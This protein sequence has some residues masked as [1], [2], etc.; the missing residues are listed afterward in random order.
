MLAEFRSFHRERGIVSYTEV[1]GSYIL[2]YVNV[3]SQLSS[4]SSFRF[5]SGG[6]ASS[7]AVGLVFLLSQLT[8]PPAALSAAAEAKTA[9]A[10]SL[11]IST[12][13]GSVTSVE[14]GTVVTLT[15]KVKAGGVA[16]T[17]GQVNF[18]NAGGEFCT[19]VDLLGTASVTSDGTAI[20]KFAPAPGSHSYKAKFLQDGQGKGSSSN[21][22]SLEVGP[23][24]RPHYSGTT[25]LGW[26]GA[27]GNYSLTA[28]V[29]G[30]GGTAAPTG[31]ISFVDTNFSD[32]VLA[33]AQLGTA[34]PGVGWSILQT[35][36]YGSSLPIAEVTADFNGDGLPDLAVLW[37][38]ASCCN[39][40]I[41][42]T[43]FFG[44]GNG[45]FTKGPTTQATGVQQSQTMIAGDFNADG[46]EDLAILSMSS[47]DD[48]NYVTALLGDGN[49][50]FAAPIT[51]VASQ[52]PDEGG[53]VITG[54]LVAA[55][56]NGDG[57]LDIAVVGD[58]VDTGGVAVL[59][60][61]GDGSFTATGANLAPD[62]GYG[63]IATGDFNG[64]GIPDLLATTYFQP[65]G[66]TVFLGQGNGK[67]TKGQQFAVDSFPSSI[68]V[69]DFNGDGKLDLAFG[70]EF[71]YST[72]VI[73]YLGKGDGT[74]LEA[75]GSPFS[76]AGQSLVAGDFNGDGKLDLAGVDNYNLQIDLFEGVGDGTFTEIVTTPNVSQSFIGP[77][78]IVAA[79]FN[80]DGVPDLA[81]LTKNQNTATALLNELTQTAT[82][83]V[84]GIAPI[85]AGTHNVKANYGGDS[86][87]G[88]SISAAVQLTAGLEPPVITPASGTYA[89]EQKVAIAEAIPGATI[90]YQAS[91]TVNTNG[92]LQY[93]GPF[94]LPYG[95]FEEISAYSTEAG[96]Q[97]SNY[98][99]ATYN[100]NLPSASNPVFSPAAG[101]YKETQTVTITDAVSGAAIYYTTN[102]TVAS[103]YSTAYN[104]PI[105]VS[106]SEV[107][108]AVAIAPGY[109]MSDVSSAQYLIGSSKTR[110]VYTVAGT[111]SVGYSGDGGPATF[112]SLEGPT[113]VARDAGGDLYIADGPTV[114]RVAAA[115]DTIT[116]VAGN[117]FLGYS[118][119]NGPATKARL[120][121]VRGLAFDK[122]GDLYIADQTN[123]VVRK[124]AAGSGTITTVAGNGKEGDTGDNGPATKA[125]LN[126]PT[127]LAVDKLGNLYIGSSAVIR[128]VA[129]ATGT[130]T[131]FAGN[132]YTGYTGDGG[133][134]TNAE[135]GLPSAMAFDASGDLYFADSQENVVRRIAA[136]TSIITTVAGTGPQR[137]GPPGNGDGGPATSAMLY[138]PTGLAI[139]SA[140]DLFIS[141]TD[142]EA[143]REVTATNK[144]INTI[145]G[146]EYSCGFLGGDGGPALAANLCYPGGLTID[147][148]GN[149]YVTDQYYETVREI[150]ALVPPPTA[151]TAS[152]VLSLAP[153]TYADAKTLTMMA[154]HGA[155]VYL[156]LDGSIPTT[157]GEGY[158]TPIAIAGPV[159]VNAIALEPGHLPSAMVTASYNVTAPAP[160][161]ITTI[162]GSGVEGSPGTGGP[163]LKAEF[164]YLYGVAADSS[165]NLYIADPYDGAVWKLTAATQKVSDVAGTPGVVGHYVG[166]GGPATKAIL[167]EPDFVALDAAGNLFISD[168]E[169]LR[170]YK[171]SAKSGIISTYAG[172]GQ[173]Y[174]YPT[175]G[176]G[177]LATDA[178]LEEPLGIAFDKSG[179]LYIADSGI[180]RIRRVNGVTG[181]ITSVAGKTDATSLGDGAL[182]TAAMLVYPVN[183]TLDGSGNLY[184]V[185]EG[186]SRI[187]AVAAKTGIIGTVAGK[188]IYGFTGDG[189]KATNASI[190]PLGIAVDAAGTV[191]F[192]N[193]DDTVRMFVPGGEI[194]T[195]AGTGYAGFV[196][197]GGPARMAELCG[198]AG[199]G[200]DRAGNLY[201]ADGCNY[202][203]RKV[204][205]PKAASAPAF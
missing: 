80:K 65:G 126:E 56:F 112:A 83:T 170:V 37:E 159:T 143:V 63:Q 128:K 107:I 178:V 191:Y 26:S 153:G 17:A 92:Y 154:V 166:E 45:T 142:D 54:S 95:G 67:F 198:V 110:F 22:A 40:A 101:S 27:P 87:Y 93:T 102:G 181:S 46:K 188:G 146:G 53:D 129:A 105:T 195:L 16:L 155:E 21:A 189:G 141:D 103:Q 48:E 187:R 144:I 14:S 81:M 35:P 31:K 197:N 121:Y 172:G 118:G 147:Q 73:V 202:R 203:V 179:N 190:G 38:V 156:T 125:E 82:A 70:Y 77:F 165:G 3:A 6:G 19:G 2:P 111:Q 34:T 108:S 10:T 43:I 151:A 60:G 72:G 44:K 61:N 158:Y 134:A 58:S 137:N 74:F 182:A 192:G 100:L 85:G 91:G 119:D 79:D 130:I 15:A 177:G 199:L 30:S 114:R 131:T 39:P 117:G 173:N 149:L 106:T 5:A 33:T 8:V 122:A 109:S 76:G 50:H 7:G 163:A 71:G 98:S 204:T 96:Y 4:K 62:Q 186:N 157:R 13:A 162:A 78:Q 9:T 20:F 89:A 18:C 69:S 127:G 184:I 11:T 174:T 90:Y 86:H 47:S 59:L 150:T 116:T 68:V 139:D 167:G 200:L 148:A 171:V 28:T 99:N 52:Q 124:V 136:G 1:N 104:G 138:D 132:G 64:D 41:N 36:A 140:G 25:T 51:S 180:G 201:I 145:A 113:T 185:D 123:D 55:D 183:V 193:V 152:P 94:F 24:P 196:G 168:S 75:P 175:F 160:A 66:A 161:T 120:G 12:A 194:S 205:F 88:R 29:E 84:T 176:D 57:K 97:Q 49:G 169:N 164:G 133:P 32:K 23:V 135:L 42:V 115:T